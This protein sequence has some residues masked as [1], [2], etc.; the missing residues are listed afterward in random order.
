M[1]DSSVYTAKL[2][3]IGVVCALNR[4]FENAEKYLEKALELDKK[5]LKSTVKHNIYVIL[6]DKM[7]KVKLKNEY[8]FIEF[9]RIP[10]T[11]S[12]PKFTGNLNIPETE[13]SL[14]IPKEKRDAGAY[15]YSCSEHSRYYLVFHKPTVVRV[16]SPNP[17][18]TRVDDCS[19]LN[20]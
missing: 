14:N 5:E 13:I 10:F 6:K 9:Y 2:N 12:E 1:A 19:P 16:K 7:K 8:I 3:N 17:G 18:G 11:P 4:T 20:K 15:K